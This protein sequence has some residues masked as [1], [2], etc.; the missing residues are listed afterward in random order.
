[1][2]AGTRQTAGF[3]DSKVGR[4]GGGEWKEERARALP[5]FGL[6]AKAGARGACARLGG[7]GARTQDRAE[8]A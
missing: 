1:M 6:S 4:G 7:V 8:P 5:A 2:V 3:G